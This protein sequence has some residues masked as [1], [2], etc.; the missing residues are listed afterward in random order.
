[1]NLRYILSVALLVLCAGCSAEVRPVPSNWIRHRIPSTQCSIA[2]PPDWRRDD[3]FASV[4]VLDAPTTNVP[5]SVMAGNGRDNWAT[6]GAY[7]S[8]MRS[9]FTNRSPHYIVLSL[10]EKAGHYDSGLQWT[11]FELVISEGGRTN[12]T[13]SSA[14]DCRGNG[15]LVVTTTVPPNSSRETES[16]IAKMLNSIRMQS[17]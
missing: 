2:C 6:I 8:A 15:F 11:G 3:D 10:S 16:T 4:L 17:E 5:A 13:T 14:V 7:A 9:A 12:V 1:M